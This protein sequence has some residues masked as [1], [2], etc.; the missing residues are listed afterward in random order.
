MVRGTIPA[1]REHGER[2]TTIFYRNMLR[3]HPDLNNYFNS[4]NQKNGR[5]PRALTAVILDFAA[6][7]NH[8]AELIPKLERMCNKHCSLGIKPEHY[9]IVGKYLIAAFGEVLGPAMTPEVQLAWHK[10]YWMLAKMLIGREAQLYKDFDKWTGWRKFKIDRKVA[11]TDEIFSFYLVPA[12]GKRLPTFLPG[13][14]ISVRIHHPDIGYLQSRQYSLSE[15]PRPDYYRISIKRDQGMEYRNSVSKSFLNPGLVSNFL[16]DTLRTG[17]TVEISHPAGEFFLDTNNNS[18]VPLVL[19]SAGVGVSPMIAIL[20]TVVQTQPTR[21]VSW[22]HGSRRLIPFE[23]HIRAAKRRCPNL[24]TNFFK[25]HL[26]DGDLAGVTYDYD[27][28]VDLARVHPE[29]LYLSHG[30]TEYYICGPEQFMLEMADYLKSQGVDS[31]R[32]KFELFSTGD[33]AF[34]H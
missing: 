30:G 32:L 7:I 14:Y 29:D 1:L 11:E 15:S 4:V 9:D 27:F 2:I 10:A 28:R 19:I 5:Q 21:S 23:E 18:S 34:E 22:I 12:D 13:Q 8:M 20:N 6:N 16:V 33:M 17:E 26:A 31:A 24:R 3:D 25:T